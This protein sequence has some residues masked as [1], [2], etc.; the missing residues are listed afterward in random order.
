MTT[1]VVN[2]R[3]VTAEPGDRYIG[4]PSRWGN[5]FSHLDGT[6]AEYRVAT[7]REAVWAYARW[8]LDQPDLL[9]RLDEL[10]GHRL[11]C[12]CHPASCHGHVLAFAC[13]HGIDALRARVAGHRYPD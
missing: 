9:A 11:V 4:R 8:L 6:L 13:D 2:K 5:P 1:T 12:W 10:R 3:A 7:R